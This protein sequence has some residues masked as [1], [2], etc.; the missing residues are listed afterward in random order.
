MQD[1][2]SRYGKQVMICEVGFA[3]ND[4]TDAEEFLKDIIAKTQSV[5]GGLG[6]FYWEPEC[7]NNW[8]GYGSGAF[9][10]NG[11]P[12]AALYVF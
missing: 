10:S 6:V 3:E 12:T 4:P 5:S 7:Y 1:M 2:V 9:G 8:Q 11:E